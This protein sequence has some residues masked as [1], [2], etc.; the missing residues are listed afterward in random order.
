MLKAHASSASALQTTVL[1]L[2]SEPYED[3]GL[4]QAQS[5]HTAFISPQSSEKIASILTSSSSASKIQA[6]SNTW[7]ARA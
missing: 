6:A 5:V 4:H 3:G 1:L 2:G 7:C